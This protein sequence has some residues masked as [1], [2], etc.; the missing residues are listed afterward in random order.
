MFLPG[1][2]ELA[3]LQQQN[4]NIT[5]L[6]KGGLTDAEVIVINNAPGYQ[7]DFSPIDPSFTFNAMSDCAMYGQG[8]G[9]GLYLCVGGIDTNNYTIVAGQ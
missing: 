9:Q 3:R 6:T 4:A 2:V 5:L 7:V 1:G 8:N